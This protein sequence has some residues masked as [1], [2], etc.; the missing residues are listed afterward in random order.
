MLKWIVNKNKKLEAVELIRS[1]LKGQ[2]YYN[3]DDATKTATSVITEGWDANPKVFDHADGAPHPVMI[4]LYCICTQVNDHLSDPDVETNN[5]LA[6]L[7]A[8]AEH[9]LSVVAVNK[10]TYVLTKRDESMLDECIE[11]ASEIFA[12]I[13]QHPIFAH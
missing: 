2:H 13:D 10:K 3:E 6:T 4:A 11:M 5:H 8:I 9:Y 12:H 7:A 1:K